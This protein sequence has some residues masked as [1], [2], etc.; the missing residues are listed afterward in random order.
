MKHF[1]KLLIPVTFLCV[2]LTGCTTSKVDNDKI[3]LEFWTLQLSNQKEFVQN[4]I[5]KYEKK[6]PNIIIK[7]V[8]VPFSE[9]EKRALASVLSGSTPDIINMNPSFEIGRA[10]V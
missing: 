5:N 1:N 9:G 8:D 3:N 7:W 4:V 6:H 2:L 10:H